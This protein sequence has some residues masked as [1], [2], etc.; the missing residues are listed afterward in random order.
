MI[1]FAFYI[2]LQKLE[3]THQ[4][5]KR[6]DNEKRKTSTLLSPFNTRVVSASDRLDV[7]EKEVF[8]WILTDADVKE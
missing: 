3:A 5:A 1:Y 2:N 8:Y 7:L 6:T 4:M